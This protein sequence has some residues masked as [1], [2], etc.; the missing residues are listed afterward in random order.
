[1]QYIHFVM[2]ALQPACSFTCAVSADRI[3]LAGADLWGIKR[4]LHLPHPQLLIHTFPS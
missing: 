2:Y 3:P 1:M 4:E